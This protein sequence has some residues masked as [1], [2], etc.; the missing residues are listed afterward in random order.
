[1]SRQF[2]QSSFEGQNP[3]LAVHRRDAGDPHPKGAFQVQHR[4]Y[5]AHDKVSRRR[6]PFAIDDVDLSARLVARGLGAEPFRARQDASQGAG[7]MQGNH[8]NIVVVFAAALL[9]VWVGAQETRPVPDDSVRVF[10]PGC[11]RGY[12]FTAGP[13]TEEHP[14]SPGIADGM[15][16]RMSA[17]RET[18]DEIR[19]REGTMIELTGLVRKDQMV[20]D[21][22]DI[23]R[24]RITPGPSP[25][26]GSRP[27]PASNQVVIDVESWRPIPG[28]CPSR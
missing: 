25:G 11:T 14:G 15:H 16:L 7:L 27:G 28:R 6:Q 18:I 2:S 21:G 23:G 19:R 1:M 9:G 17:P 4:A 22:V 12:V 20:R 5:S 8:M 13:R 10:L 3:G 24:V 26:G